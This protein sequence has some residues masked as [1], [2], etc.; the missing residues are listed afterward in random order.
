SLTDETDCKPVGAGG[1]ALLTICA[2]APSASSPSLPLVDP[3]RH[4]R[5][6]L[7]CRPNRIGAQQKAVD[8]VVSD[9]AS[10]APD[11]EF[12]ERSELGDL[13]VETVSR[14]GA[15]GDLRTH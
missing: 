4:A 7:R 1:V 14:G 11:S 10:R 2:G 5:L 12:S 9:R 3:H 8:V 13:G 6:E 15:Q